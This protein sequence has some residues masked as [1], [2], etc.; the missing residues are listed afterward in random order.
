MPDTPQGI[1]NSGISRGRKIAVV[2]LAIFALGI[3]VL[4]GINFKNLIKGP[5]EGNN[6]LAERNQAQK[7]CPSGNCTFSQ[8]QKQKNKDT[9]NDGLSDWEELNIHNTSPYLKDS[10]SDGMSDKQEIKQGSD[11][12]CPA[13]EDCQNF[14]SEKKYSTSSERANIFPASS[15]DQKSGK[16]LNGLKQ[17][18]STGS[19]FDSLD[20]ATA[21]KVL[22]G[23][24]DAKTLRQAFLKMGI[25]KEKLNSISDEQLMRMYKNSLNKKKK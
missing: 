8:Q 12:N 21:K 3:I 6:S 5:F 24:G 16:L 11:P 10:D 25:S 2:F 23:E 15:T 4:W 20:S 18:N 14:A 13:G 22:K 9:D 7:T 19:S 1:N 17:N